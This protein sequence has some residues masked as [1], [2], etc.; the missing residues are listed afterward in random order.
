MK[1]TSGKLAFL[2]RISIKHYT[3]I[4]AV[5]LAITVMHFVLQISFI[6]KENLRAVETAP[7]IVQP[8]EQAVQVIEINP[9]E[10]EVRKVEIIT[11]PEVVQPVAP[12]QTEAAP[13]RI[14]SR[15]KPVRESRAERLRRAERILT[16]A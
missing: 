8:P 9:K 1:K 6:Q 12:R 11:I 14:P 7:E 3:I 5:I 4:G 2:R 15:K 16:G 10:Y 13:V